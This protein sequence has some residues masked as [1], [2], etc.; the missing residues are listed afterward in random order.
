VL[1]PFARAGKPYSPPTLG[2]P[3]H[4][5]LDAN[6]GQLHPLIAGRVREALA[7]VPLTRYPNAS[8]L[9]ARLAE[10][11][12]VAT[13]RVLVTAGGDDAIDRA[14]R[15]TLL[16][17]DNIVLAAP[18]FEIFARCAKLQGAQVRSSGWEGDFPLASLAAQIDDRTRMVVVVSPNNP[19]GGVVS[20]EAIAT[21]ARLAPHAMVLVDYAYIEFADVDPTREV[22][23]FRN[24]VMV[25]TLSKALGLAGLRVGYAI[26]APDCIAA[27]RAVGLPFSVSVA[28]LAAAE[29]AMDSLDAIVPMVAQRAHAERASLI[30]V[31]RGVARVLPSQANFVLAD[32]G[33]SARAERVW[34]GLGEK[35]IS[36]RRFANQ[37][38]GSLLARSL[39][40]SCPLDEQAERQLLASLREVVQQVLHQGGA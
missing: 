13:E 21:L 29:A 39:R 14:C 28:G 27:M 40:I 30:E 16:A 23:G 15:A 9:A 6:E 18:T 25:R 19:T 1:S 37:A 4:L 34:R 31:L 38:E 32:F 17:G 11:F 24:V 20:L 22:L 10:Q 5:H 35:G 3:I 7:N 12:G 33:S 26:G 2:A 8:P 36:V